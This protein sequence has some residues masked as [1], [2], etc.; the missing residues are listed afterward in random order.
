M[1]AAAGQAPLT[2]AFAGDVNLEGRLADGRIGGLRWHLSAADL[3]IVN[4]E[5]AVT[6]RGTAADKQYVF[7]G[8]ASALTGLVGSGVDVVS[9]ANNHGMDFGQTGL[10]D[11]LAAAK[12][13]HLPLVGAGLDETAAYA[14]YRTTRKGQRIAVLG[15]TQVLDEGL[16]A[17]W[18]AGPHRPGLASAYRLD[19]LLASVRRARADSDLVVVFLH[20]GAELKTCPT[21]RQRTLARQLADAGADVVVG[22]HA[23]V[24]LG[25]G[26]LGNTYVDYGLGNFQFYSGHG[27]TAQTG[28]LTLTMQGRRT[29]HARWDPGVMVSGRPEPLSGADRDAALVGREQRRACTGLDAP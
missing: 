16:K 18:T 12:A 17:A 3:A 13:A 15:A 7:R 2:L 5:S 25:D 10:R 23:H 21:E 22:S 26:R 14:P 11:T 27:P 4:L 1:P 19:T 24:L 29:Q 6:D 20:W 28:V 9:L 8:P